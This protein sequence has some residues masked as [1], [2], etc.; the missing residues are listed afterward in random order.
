[1]HFPTTN[2]V[3][4]HKFSTVWFCWLLTK[5]DPLHAL[6]FIFKI[7]GV[8]M[9]R[10]NPILEEKMKGKPFPKDISPIDFMIAKVRTDLKSLIKPIQKTVPLSSFLSLQVSYLHFHRKIV[11][12]CHQCGK[13]KILKILGS[14]PVAGWAHLIFPTPRYRHYQNSKLIAHI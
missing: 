1:M 8:I 3:N 10:L 9:D 4:L 6:Y 12:R 2:T 14:R 13:L 5:R 11:I 7:Q